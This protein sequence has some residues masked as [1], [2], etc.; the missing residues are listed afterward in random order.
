MNSQFSQWFNATLKLVDDKDIAQEIVQQALLH[1]VEEGRKPWK[2]R[3]DH[4]WL[5]GVIRNLSR[6]YW[7]KGALELKHR[8]WIKTNI[9]IQN[10]D[11]ALLND[12]KEFD[13]ILSAIPRR[14]KLILLLALQGLGKKEILQVS[15]LSDT[16]FRKRLSTLKS[17][18]EKQ[19]HSLDFSAVNWTQFD[20]GE[21]VKT[22][23]M[24]LSDY[25][26]F[27]SVDCSGHI[28]AINNPKKLTK[29]R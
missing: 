23:E 9:A 1:A 10:R 29:R 27:A 24:D 15:G 20:N 16:A 3:N 6:Q 26:Q 17:T 25:A 4:F 13:T 22:A 14:L 7:K 11:S 21:G 2:M 12:H 28:F 19:P 5:Q 8:S 18:L